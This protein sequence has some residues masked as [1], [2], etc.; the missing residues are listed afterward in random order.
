MPVWS[1]ASDKR[2]HVLPLAADGFESHEKN[3]FKRELAHESPAPRPVGFRVWLWCVLVT[4]LVQKEADMV[5]SVVH[6]RALI[7]N[8]MVVLVFIFSMA[9]YFPSISTESVVDQA[10]MQGEHTAVPRGP[11]GFV[12]LAATTEPDVVPASTTPAIESTTSVPNTSALKRVSELLEPTRTSTVDPDA[13]ENA[14]LVTAMASVSSTNI[15]ILSDDLVA[16]SAP[17]G[18]TTAVQDSDEVALPPTLSSAAI[19][20]TSVPT[21]FPVVEIQHSTSVS[22][23]A[24]TIVE[25]AA[26]SPSSQTT[27]SPTQLP[28]N[29]ADLIWALKNKSTRP[30]AAEQSSTTPEHRAAS[31]SIA[32]ELSTEATRTNSQPSLPMDTRSTEFVTSAGA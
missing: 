12:H 6:R 5:V 17:P 23:I 14:V 32:P 4:E 24:P 8:V 29:I 30:N 11:H 2:S 25:N 22:S 19:E 20:I 13:T 9:L 18:V 1:R 16:S 27:Q 7:V 26:L 15:A 21:T 3:S 31:L 28:K 10:L